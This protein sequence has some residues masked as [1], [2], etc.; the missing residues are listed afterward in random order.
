MN[1]ICTLAQQAQASAPAAAPAGGGLMG[2]VPMIVIMGVMIFFMWH[3]Q[4][5]Q[6]K[7]RQAM[8]DSLQVGAKVLTIGGI[9]GEILTVKENTFV[10]QIAENTKVEVAKTAVNSV[11]EQEAAKEPQAK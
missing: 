1:M 11:A 6:A 7:Q 5:K 2:F 10:I 9:Y 4:K 8:L 3:S